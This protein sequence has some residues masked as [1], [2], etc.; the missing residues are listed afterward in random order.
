MANTLRQQLARAFELQKAGRLGDAEAGYAAYLAAFPDDLGALNNAAVVALQNG[1]LPLAVSRFRKLVAL[2]PQKAHA[3]N[4]FAYA[5]IQADRPEDAIEHLDRA[6]TLNP[7][8]ATAHNNLGIAYERTDRRS[9]AIA[10][11]ERALALDPRYADAAANLAEVLNGDDDTVRPRGGAGRAVD[12]PHASRRPRCRRG[13]RRA[14]RRSRRRAP[15]AGGTR[16]DEAATRGLLAGAGHAAILGRRFRGCGGC[17]AERADP[18]SQRSS[19]QVRGGGG[20]AR[21]WRLPTRLAGLRRAARRC[22]RI[23]APFRRRAEMVGRAPRRSAARDLRTGAWRR[24]PVR[25][26]RIGSAPTRP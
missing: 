18:R 15:D 11:V 20:A 13:R 8:Y 21:A 5:L 26:L 4:N 3:H 9:E 7:R 12:E 22:V 6:I 24:Y 25:A 23:I 10:A 1:D 16:A 19:G 14:R 2:A 17:L